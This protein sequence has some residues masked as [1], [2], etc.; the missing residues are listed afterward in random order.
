MRPWAGGFTLI[1]LMVVLVIMA[2]LATSI[3]P[4]VAS[5]LQR[6]GLKTTRDKLCELL[7]FA[8]MSAVTRRRPVVVNLD[9]RRKLCWVSVSAVSLPWL[10]DRPG[11]KTHVLATMTLP[12]AV[13]V[14][15]IHGEESRL[16]VM[17]TQ[18]WETV[19]F[20]SDGRT[21]DAVIELTDVQGERLAIKVV[22][23]TG[24]VHTGEALR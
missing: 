14:T 4:S 2:L 19:T 6:N 12:E 24:E 3:A 16:G 11:P 22:G 5:G 23:V 17:A 20:R 1:E 10:E 7:D 18:V 9:A 8:Y 13:Q 21:E 15:V